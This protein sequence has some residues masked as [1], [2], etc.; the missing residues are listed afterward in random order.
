MIHSNKASAGIYIHI[1]F[2][3]SKCDYCHFI[4]FPL[5]ESDEARYAEA[6]SRELR[7]AETNSFR[8]TRERPDA[9]S[10]YFGGGT[11]SLI[12]AEHIADMIAECRRVFHIADDCEISLEANP[13]TVLPEK[14]A[15]YRAAGVNRISV[16]AQSFSNAEL[17]AVGRVHTAAEIFSSIDVL[18]AAGFENINLDLMLGLPEQT[19]LSWR[20]TLA[21]A[22]NLPITHISVYM[23]DIDEASPF[24]ARIEAGELSLPD[25]DLIADLYLETLEFLDSRGFA[26][27][28]ISN[29]SRS[30]YECRHNLKYWR[31]VPVYGFGLG[32]HSFDG[33]FRYANVGELDAYCRQSPVDWCR[34]VTE[35]QAMEETFFLG[36][37]LTE[38]I[39]FKVL[40]D[41]C[42]VMSA[43]DG[44][45][46]S[47]CGVL[48]A[49]DGVLSDECRV[50]SASDGVQSAEC[51]VLSAE[52]GVLS[53]ECRVMSASDGVMSD[54]CGVMSAECGYVSVAG[55]VQSGDVSGDVSGGLSVETGCVDLNQMDTDDFL[56]SREKSLNEFLSQ[57]LIELIPDIHTQHSTLSTPSEALNT[58]NSSLSTP[59]SKLSTQ[60]SALHTQ[61]SALS[62]HHSSLI[63]QYSTLSTPNSK[64]STQH[65]A[66]STH[67]SALITQHSSLSIR[68][69]RKG[70]LLSNEV[71]QLFVT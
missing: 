60:H 25:D 62:T 58:P 5:D 66:L 3:R 41:E 16:G 56:K 35:S 39:T 29:F 31:R 61:H 68:L 43:S 42:R 10:I 32:A 54:E 71:L 23:L 1:P 40:S 63:T 64:L 13:G 12:P 14:A 30:G 36:L 49:S 9:D 15:I 4:S 50:Q 26:Q 6:V 38:G 28:E 37:R 7:S 47:E 70:M 51:G 18:R 65:S 67:H 53:D 17:R 33:R 2:C 22:V 48:S 45:Q 8:A 11:P 52:C 44:V 34:E 24:S 21:A 27:Y 20:D 55:G 69:T 19:A 59:N 46:S 57:G